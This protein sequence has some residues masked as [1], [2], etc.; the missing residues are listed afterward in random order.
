[1]RAVGVAREL[2]G[3]GR[4]ELQD[5]L[6]PAADGQEDLL[7]LRRGATLAAADVAVPAVR[8]VLSYRTSPKADPVE[9]LANVDDDAH[10]LAIVLLLERLADGS[11][12]DMEPELVD[13]DA[14]LVLVL[15]R[16]LAAVLVLG[17]LPL[18]ADTLL[19]E[20]VV[21]LLSKLGNRDDVVLAWMVR[22]GTD[23]KSVGI[24]LT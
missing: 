5:F 16:P 2:N 17:V 20:V 8:N 22:A 11:E 4:G 7:A 12:H 9:S 1:M 3:L 23:N 13:V 21:G 24:R 19:E 18:G 6:E 10:D 15:V 14:A